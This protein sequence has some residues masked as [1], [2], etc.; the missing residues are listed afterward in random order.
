MTVPQGPEP[1]FRGTR[2]RA[3]RTGRA[4]IYNGTESV[5]QAATW[6]ELTAQERLACVLHVV[7][8]KTFRQLEQEMALSRTRIRQIMSC[9]E[10]IL[11]VKGHLQLAFWMGRHW[12]EIDGH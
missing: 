5:R 7:Q 6:K 10:R 1:R 9:A 12:S 11:R 3:E 2:R 8:N 4:A